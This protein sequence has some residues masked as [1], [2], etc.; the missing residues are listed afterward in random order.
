MKNKL[1]VMIGAAGSGKSTFAKQYLTDAVYVSRDEIRFSLLAEGEPYF[2]REDQVY[3]EFIWKIYN[4]LLN[5]HKDVVADATHLNDKS[6]AKLFKAL[7]LDFSKYYIIAVYINTSLKAC[8]DR[9]ELRKN[10]NRAYV[11]PQQIQK[12]FF[13]KKAPT[14]KEYNGIFNELWDIYTPNNNVPIIC[15]YNREGEIK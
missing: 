2:S 5:E 9:N 7:P 1:Y 10:D 11:P 4:T 6:R 8:L 12:M 13:Q 3:R 14:F 15:K